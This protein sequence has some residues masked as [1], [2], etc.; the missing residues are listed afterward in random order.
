MIFGINFFIMTSTL[1]IFAS[2]VVQLEGNSACKAFTFTV[3]RSGDISGSSTAAWAVSSA[4]ATGDDFVGSIFPSGTVTFAAGVT[5]QII[6]VEVNGNF[7]IENDESF[8]I[9]LSDPVGSTISTAMAYGSIIRDDATYSWTTP[10][11]IASEDY[12]T[13]MTTGGD[14]SIYIDD[15]TRVNPGFKSSSSIV[16]FAKEIAYQYLGKFAANPEFLEKMC[17]AFGESFAPDA[18]LSL[19]RNW[20]KWNVTLP[21]IEIIP[22]TSLNGAY[23]GY[24]SMTDTIYLSDEFIRKSTLSAI[25]S[26]ILEEFGHSIDRLLNDSD[27]LGDEGQVFASLVQGIPLPD[28]ELQAL[29][30]ENDFA[31][32][33]VHGREIE[34]EQAEFSDGG[35]K[36]SHKV[37]SLDGARAIYLSY[38]RYADY[39]YCPHGDRDRPINDRLFIRYAGKNIFEATFADLDEH[40]IIQIPLNLSDKLEFIV[41]ADTANY[42]PPYPYNPDLEFPFE[43]CNNDTGWWYS[44]YLTPI[45]LDIQDAYTAVAGGDNKKA[46]IK[47]PVI[48]S[49]ACSRE[50]TVRYFTLAGTAADGIIGSDKRDYRPVTGTLTFAP[51]EIR[52][53]IEIEVCGDRPVNS[54]SNSIFEYLAKDKSYRDWTKSQDIDFGSSSTLSYGEDFGYRVN[55]FFNDTSDFQAVGLTSDENFFVIISDPY[56]V[57]INTDSALNKIYLL[58]LLEQS[59]GKDYS[60]SPAYQAALQALDS[61]KD[62]SWA[63]ATGT[64]YDQGKAPILAIRGSEKNIFDWWDDFNPMGVGYS[65]YQSTKKNKDDNVY[66]WLDDVSHPQGTNVSFKPHITGHSL[67]G[68]LTQWVAADY[69]SQGALGDIVTFNSPGISTEKAAS[70][71]GAENVTHYITSTDVVSLAGSSYIDGKYILFDESFSFMKPFAVINAHSHPVIVPDIIQSPSEPRI[72]K[73]LNFS[74]KTFASVASLNDPLF[75]FLPDPDY[76]V[77]L[78]AVS[79]IFGPK[80]GPF[81]AAALVNRGTAEFARKQIGAEIYNHVNTVKF[82]VEFAKL[83]VQAAGNAAKIWS[84]AAWNAVKEWKDAAWGSV[85]NWITSAWNATTQWVD[86]AWNATT[87]WTS[88][89]WDATTEW[90]SDAWDATT[91]WTSDAWN[92]TTEWTNDAWNATTEWANDAWD[93]TTKWTSDAWDAIGKWT[94]EALQATTHWSGAAWQATTE[95]TLDVWQLTADWTPEVWQATTRWTDDIWQATTVIIDISSKITLAVAP[96]GALEDGSSKLVYT[97]TRTGLTSVPLS[98]YYTVDGTASADD[99]SGIPENHRISFG[100]SVSSVDLV[101]NLAADNLAEADETIAI[102]ISPGSDYTIDTTTA[103]IGTIIND[104]LPA[105]SLSINPVDVQEDGNSNLIYSFYRTGPTS[106][107]L[108]VYYTVGGTASADDYSG[109]PATRAITFAEGRSRVD[110]EV[111]PTADILVEPDETVAITISANSSYSVGSI[112]AAVGTITNDDFYRVPQD[113]IFNKTLS[114]VFNAGQLIGTLTTEDPDSTNG[115]TYK[116]EAGYQDGSIFGIIDNRLIIGNISSFNSKEEFNLRVTTT[117]TTGLS[118]TK[119][120][121][122]NKADLKLTKGG[123]NGDI[124]IHPSLDGLYY[125]FQYAGVFNM[126]TSVDKNFE[127]QVRLVKGITWP[128]ASVA[129]GIAIQSFGHFFAIDASQS[130]NNPII[131]VDG[132]QVDLQAGQSVSVG[133]GRL[134]RNSANEFNFRTVDNNIIAFQVYGHNRDIYMNMQFNL[135]NAYVNKLTGLMGNLDG[136]SHNDWVTNPESVRIAPEQNLFNNASYLSIAALTP[137]AD[138]YNSIIQKPKPGYFLL[139]RSGPIDSSLTVPILL[140]GSAQAGMDY[141][142]LP[143]MATFA[144]GARTTDLKIAPLL[145]SN[146][147]EG[148]ETVTATIQPVPGYQ[149][150]GLPTATVKIFDSIG[151]IVGIYPDQISLNEGNASASSY[152]FA[153]LRQGD[154]SLPSSVDWSVKGYGL[155]PVSP[156]DFASSSF[157]SGSVSFSPGEASKAISFGVNGDYDY[158]LDEEFS[159]NLS[160][161]IGAGAAIGK[162]FAL[163]KTLNDDTGLAIFSSS[164]SIQPEG[165]TGNTSLSFTVARKG[166]ILQSSSV[167]WSVLGSGTHPATADDFID[168]AYP[169]GVLTFNPGEDSANVTINV[170]GDTIEEHSEVFEIR[171]SNPSLGSNIVTGAAVGI[172]QDD[173]ALISIINAG[174]DRQLEGDTG[175]TPYSFTIFRFGDN[176][177]SSTVDW[178]VEGSGPNPATANDFIGGQ[179]PSGKVNFYPGEISTVITVFV[180]ADLNYECDQEFTVSLANAVLAQIDKSSAKAVIVND[181]KSSVGVRIQNNDAVT[182]GFDQYKIIQLARSNGTEA[183]LTVNLSTSGT[184]THGQDYRLYNTITLPAGV[185]SLNVPLSLINDFL[186]EDPEQIVITLDPGL[187]YTIDPSF[188][189]AS[190]SIID[191]SDPVPLVFWLN[192]RAKI[193]KVS[194]NIPEELVNS[195][196]FDVFITGDDGFID[197]GNDHFDIFKDPILCLATG[198]LIRTPS[199]NRPVEELQIGDLVLTPDGPQPLK[200]LGVSTRHVNNLRATGRMPIRIQ[201]G[202]FGENLPSADIYCTPSHAFALGDCLV[203]AQALING[204]SIYQLEQLSEFDQRHQCEQRSHLVEHKEVDSFT[205]YSLEFNQHVLVWANDLLTESYLPT[206]R[207]GELTRMAWNNYDCYLNLY[208]SSETMN[209]L[210]MSRI[211]FARQLPL[212][213]RERFKLGSGLDASREE[214]CLTL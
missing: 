76:F 210:P 164:M 181:D 168:Q 82:T 2:N 38:G 130:V 186:S 32:I 28:S 205:Y 126:S 54:E 116:L 170:R 140:G 5:S 163:G 115:F 36:D 97:F 190:F 150:A 93:A 100:P 134:N 70:F 4:Q 180:K 174:P 176:S 78:I 131:A 62:T 72:K 114:D 49:E 123:A 153:L 133:L 25:V 89:A 192:H 60:T 84:S 199:G 194:P 177:I 187:N 138:E 191:N 69:S 101:V 165:N 214:L 173:D 167:Q 113:I 201:A 77:F 61:L 64:I 52:K 155:N 178:A 142:L 19:A 206:Y 104:D 118:F 200:F 212:R 14:G 98:V 8:T 74:E 65:Q 80:E 182:E 58:H 148:I 31:T 27:A 209:E 12:A 92:A 87:K 185:S 3:N 129:N 127:V 43:Q 184:A 20:E 86:Q 172:V 6:T 159:V 108:T 124:H 17:L 137:F 75:S 45:V 59:L 50:T 156:N 56:D 213:I 68:A 160:N 15:M 207:D 143:A 42:P 117:D 30:Q 7:K 99:Y 151:S 179:L 16:Y 107:P 10:Q 188:S 46:T 154:L 22:A 195:I 33:A 39:Y 189:E 203:E 21:S 125:D 198:T 149:L 94:P 161:P 67:G 132:N 103:V 135:S 128:S 35:Q 136:N 145:D 202:V 79:R 106:A 85:S 120:F 197:S 13:A 105:I 96:G 147:K 88:D 193:L 26:I 183:S 139:T 73:P 63:F 175:V 121:I 90:T 23:G 9:T 66:K 109:V 196:I 1:S 83:S 51:G 169:T 146:A 41:D 157:P 37:I 11:E 40:I 95:W 53:E 24:A 44:G 141:G 18:A 204:Q 122:I 111:D 57:K 47:F 48:L 102:T 91:K 208:Q 171:L 144:A 81:V 158:E 71:T 152:T 166:N 110:L 55:K 112:A 29:Y 162:A 34:I 211:P 119:D